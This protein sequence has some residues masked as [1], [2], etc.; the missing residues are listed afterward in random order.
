MR[1]RQLCALALGPWL[2]GVAAAQ[3]SSTRRIT[4]RARVPETSGTVY[5][6]GNLPE[7]GPWDPA[8][9]AMDGFGAERRLALDVPAGMSL[10]FKLTLGSW[11]REALDASGQPTPNF[12]VVAD[13]DR[14][15]SVE[16]SA[17]KSDPRIFMADPA[18]G[19]VL[20]TLRYWH[21]VPSRH[22]R[23]TRHV[24]L[25]LPPS[26]ANSGARRYPVLY[27]HDGQNLF[28]PRLASTG[29]DWG[30]DEAVVRSAAAGRMPEV[31]VVGVWNTADRM[32]EYS[33]WHAGRAYGR[34]LIEELMR[35]VN[36]ELRT[37][38]GPRHT[39]VMGSSM[40]GLVS[41]DLCRRHPEVFGA[42]A[43]LSTSPF[44]DDWLEEKFDAP[45][46]LVR[47]IE[48]GLRFPRGPRLY[49]DHGTAGGDELI[50][51]MQ[52]KVAVW[53]RGQ[54]WH[55]GRDFVARRIEGAAHNETS[56]RARLDEVLTFLYR[57]R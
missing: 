11:A 13:A 26:Y 41:F 32:R 40:G 48:R 16:V 25:W 27:M 4:V 22:L 21:D 28:D 31:I 17:F 43:C 50:A 56:W 19:G 36:A 54:G 51:P 46:N 3:G 24:S 37:L 9:R 38:K 7:L 18:G 23:T 20:G 42:G 2:P 52:A 39:T 1:R 30:V 5:L 14:E 44:A 57:A 8:K 33:P 55:E 35:E 29:I 10:E 12:R 47:D 45:P 15:I 6:T 53:L 34:F 49:L